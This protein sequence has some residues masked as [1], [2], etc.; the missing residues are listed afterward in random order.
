MAGNFTVNN[1]IYLLNGIEL[2]TLGATVEESAGFLDMPKRKLGVNTSWPD[3]NGL[4][5]DL[6]AFIYEARNCKVNFMIAKGAF[7]DMQIN[8][9]NLYAQLAKPGL[10]YLKLAGI[11]KLFLVY[12]ADAISPTRETKNDAQLSAASL[13]VNLVEPHPDNK[14]FFTIL[15]DPGSAGLAIACS[16]P[17]TI[18]WGDGSY[19]YL[20]SSDDLTHNYL[21]AGTYCITIWGNM[22]G[23]TGIATTNCTGTDALYHGGVVGQGYWDDNAKWDDEAPWIDNS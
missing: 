11:P 6:S 14:Q 2:S 16:K 7:L 22:D 13:Q 21:T 15:D 19:S 5:V 12:L 1:S 8:L 23:I 4:E 18:D 3:Q 17:I 20:E 10:Q 9:N